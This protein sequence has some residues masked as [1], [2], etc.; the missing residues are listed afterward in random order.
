MK[1]KPVNLLARVK[2]IAIGLG[3][4]VAIASLVSQSGAVTDGVCGNWGPGG[5]VQ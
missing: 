2:R 3:L 5:N 1:S 4:P